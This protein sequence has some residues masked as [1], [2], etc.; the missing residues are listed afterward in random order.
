MLIDNDFTR[1]ISFENE[2]FRIPCFILFLCVLE[3]KIKFICIV[4]ETEIFCNRIV[5]ALL[6]FKRM[7]TIGKHHLLI[8]GRY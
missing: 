1:H 7:V 4:I 2:N 8:G 5:T 6:I 3:M